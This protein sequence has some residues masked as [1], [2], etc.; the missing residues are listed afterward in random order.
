MWTHKK[1]HVNSGTAFTQ[2][3]R[4]LNDLKTRLNLG[5]AASGKHR[6]IL[7][8]GTPIEVSWAM[9]IPTIKIGNPNTSGEYVCFM[10]VFSG[11]L[12]LGA[13]TSATASQRFDYG[14]PEFAEEAKV[15]HFNDA[16][17]APAGGVNGAVS[18]VKRDGAAFINSQCANSAEA[19]NITLSRWSAAQLKAQAVLPGSTFSGFMRRYV[20][21]I[22]G[23]N[24]DY[25]LATSSNTLELLDSENAVVA[26]FSP[27][28]N[29]VTG[30]CYVG[31]KFVFI[32]PV[33]SGTSITFNFYKTNVTPCAAAVLEYWASKYGYLLKKRINEETLSVGDLE[34]ETQGNKILTIAMS[35]VS[36]GSLANASVPISINNS[37][38]AHS[39]A[40]NFG[41]DRVA[42]CVRN[43]ADAG[44]SLLRCAFSYVDGEYAAALSSSVVGQDTRGGLGCFMYTPGYTGVA[45]ANVSSLGGGAGFVTG[46]RIT[47]VHGYYVSGTNEHRVVYHSVAISSAVDGGE[48]KTCASRAVGFVTDVTSA[49]IDAAY[50]ES[51]SIGSYEAIYS[52]GFYEMQGVDILWSTVAVRSAATTAGDSVADVAISRNI[53]NGSLSS[54]SDISVAGETVTPPTTLTGSHFQ[55]DGDFLLSDKS[56]TPSFLLGVFTNTLAA[57]NYADCMDLPE[58]TTNTVW[59]PPDSG[60]VAST[61]DLSVTGGEKTVTGAIAYDDIFFERSFAY[62]KFSIG[63][64]EILSISDGN[65]EAIHVHTYKRQ[66]FDGQFS[67]TEMSFRHP[68]A[69]L[70]EGQFETSPGVFVPWSVTFQIDRSLN[71]R[72]LYVY[73]TSSVVSG[74]SSIYARRDAGG[75]GY[76]RVPRWEGI[77]G[78]ATLDIYDPKTDT[79]FTETCGRNTMA[80]IGPISGADPID[81]QATMP[82]PTAPTC[83]NTFF[84]TVLQFAGANNP[85]NSM[86]SSDEHL[87]MYADFYNTR[88]LN[89]RAVSGL[90]T[91]EAIPTIDPGDT[92]R[93]INSDRHTFTGGYP[94]VNNPS[95]IGWA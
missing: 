24:R 90:K 60:P 59:I 15:L 43:S 14:R 89:I 71:A 41:L 88:L 46:S 49:V 34:Q 80:N 2:A 27:Y 53:V 55:Y 69:N 68:V 81:V 64:N 44:T 7:S 75:A 78:P 85:V 45:Y 17:C 51:A 48:I 8:D 47:P 40:I 58:I 30:L 63:D 77:I 76:F 6:R 21:A 16:S 38:T 74:Q 19:G 31:G 32:K 94:A 95:F 86:Y 39:Y 61:G 52:S 91:G 66:Q 29:A 36:I 11:M 72:S 87:K 20:Q 33:L 54:L 56:A 13:D 67:S 50:C 42:V 1:G 10:S 12:D 26:A 18:Y 70:Y 28:A 22:Y 73:A 82:V 57:L 92:G 5:G 83:F 35:E 65:C 37:G 4:A 3:V 9:G 25:R 62:G 23:S 84:S 93:S 79:T